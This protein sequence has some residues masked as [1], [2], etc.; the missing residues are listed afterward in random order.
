[1][2]PCDA[3]IQGT[4]GTATR[5]IS[6]IKRIRLLLS[7]IRRM[8][9]AFL[10]VSLLFLS[11]HPFFFRFCSLSVC[12]AHP[13][14]CLLIVTQMVDFPTSSKGSLPRSHPILLIC[15]LILYL[16]F[17]PF[18]IFHQ[19]M[20][21]TIFLTHFSLGEFR[22]ASPIQSFTISHFPEHPVS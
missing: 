13:I 1:M 17:T 6:Q 12:C 3:Q 9:R 2:A 10:F 11:Y 4:L 7:W 19:A 22:L 5:T 18:H 20:A 15:S 21:I 14:S 16:G 8:N